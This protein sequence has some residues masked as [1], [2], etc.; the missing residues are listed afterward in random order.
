MAINSIDELFRRL[1]TAQKTAEVEVILKE[2]GDSASIGLQKT[3]GP[4]ECS[5]VPY[6]ESESNEST[7]GLGTKPGRSLTERVTNGID[8]M[9]ELA[10][11]RDT[12]E[13]PTAPSTAAEKWYGRAPTG[14][15]EGLFQSEGKEGDL[16]RAIGVV[17]C[18]SGCDGAPTIDVFDAGIGLAP[19]EMPHTILSLQKGN[20]VKKHYL[21]GR[22]GQGGAST[23]GFCKYAVIMSR[24]H[25]SPEVVGFT[26]VREV[27]PGE[28]YDVDVYAYLTVD[29]RIPSVDVGTGPLALYPDSKLKRSPE[30]SHGT[31]VRHLGYD[32]SGLDKSL[33]S[34]PGNLYHFLHM[35]M[36]DPLVP[37][38]ILDL[39][40]ADSP[41]DERVGGSRNRL[42]KYVGKGETEED[43]ET[44]MISV[45]HHQ[46]MEYIVP[47]GSTEPAIGVE[48]WVVQAKRWKNKAKGESTLRSSSNELFVQR[49]QPVVATLNGQNQGELPAKFIKDL[50]YA[51][52]SKHIVVHVDTSKTHRSIRRQLFATTREG[53]KEGAQLD[54][55][56]TTLGNIL[57]DD[58]RLGEIEQQLTD[59][60]VSRDSRATS[61]AVKKEITRLL[62]NAGFSRTAEG[63]DDGE[64]DQAGAGGAASTGEGDH[65][66]GG[67][68]GGGETV[69]LPTLKF[70]DVTK[71]D[72]VAPTAKIRVRLDGRSL[73]RI[74]TDAD[75][76]FDDEGLISLEFEPEKVEIASVSAL[77]GGRKQWRLRAAEGAKV[78]DSGTVTAVLRTPNGGELRSAIQFEVMAPLGPGT[79]AQRG[80]VPDFEVLPISPDSDDDLERWN[81]LWPEHE[82]A[83]RATKAEVAYKVLKAG[84]KTIVYYSTAY[85][86]YVAKVERMKAKSKVLAELFEQNYQI[87]VGYHA[88]LQ[89]PEQEKAENGEQA[90]LEGE[91][92][93]VAKL[94]IQL[95]EK[96]AELQRRVAQTTEA[97]DD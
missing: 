73:L 58:K 36:F 28:D 53:F 79:R 94:Q 74:A 76:R 26:I 71:W 5:W 22:F 89:L 35:S 14:P 9:L 37:F 84:D 47:L 67:G 66:G 52:L 75:A 49:G 81:E 48:Y 65:Q 68:G 78:G 23:L 72:I 93:R 60:L 25:E 31:H 62:R 44:G 95:A 39:R 30:L 8:A 10:R 27:N 97:G 59:R 21:M 34:S 51:M 54:N 82:S 63:A 4:L 40:N 20:K 70:P 55:L 42:M 77:R 12:G 43:E 16:S 88:I 56:T 15:R 33:Q 69:P 1:L 64:G 50:G 2:I 46:E 92:C 38:R 87:W 7:I 45:L 24:D 41:K 11:E 85:G 13:P 61:D 18:D 57:K 19:D 6:G 91:R 96:L 32:L 86:P 80:R 17:L 83:S 90:M 29:G 3:F